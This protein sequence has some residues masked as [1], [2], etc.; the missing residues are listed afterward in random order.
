MARTKKDGR[1][2]RLHQKIKKTHK[3]DAWKRTV[4]IRSDKQEMGAELLELRDR[5]R[6]SLQLYIPEAP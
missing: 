3:Y 2:Y 1:R 5:F 4:Y 6:Y